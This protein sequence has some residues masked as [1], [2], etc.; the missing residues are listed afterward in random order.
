MVE[1]SRTGVVKELIAGTPNRQGEPGDNEKRAMIRVYDTNLA[2]P[3]SV[4]RDAA[5]AREAMNRFRQRAS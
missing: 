1:R 2:L 5:Q 4:E 3:L